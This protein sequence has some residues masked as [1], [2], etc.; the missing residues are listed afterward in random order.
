[1]A[2]ISDY[3]SL[4]AAVSDYLARDDLSTFIPNFIQNAENKLYRTLNLRNE[5]TALNVSVSSGVG[6]VPADYKAL[7]LAYVDGNPVHVLQYVTLD[8]LYRDYPVR[9][10]GAVPSVIAREGTNFIFGPSPA[11]FTLKGVYYAKQDPLRT[12]D[13]SW[14]VTNAPEVLLY[15]ALLEAEAFIMN[16]PRLMV[17]KEFY[18]DSIEC[19]KQE[20]ANSA[21]PTQALKV[22]T[23]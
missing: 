15:G 7:K 9:S 21:F 10:G 2:I 16:D 12:T 23:A 5:E 4:Q 20:E 11:D 8:E 3:S 22:R 18:R 14:Y 13:P 6:T 1:M 19:L 17:W